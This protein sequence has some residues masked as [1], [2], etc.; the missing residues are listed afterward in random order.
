MSKRQIVV[1]Y[2]ALSAALLLRPATVHATYS[3][4]A[5][6]AKTQACGV[7]V[8]T[9]NLAV[10]ASVPYAQAGVGALASQFETNPHY[11]PRGLTLLSQALSPDEVLKRLLAED[12]N[13]DGAGP[14]ARQVGIVSVAGRAAN[15]TGDEAQHAVWAG[16]RSGSGYTIQG[17]GLTGPQVAEAME[18]AFLYTPGSLAEK[19][20][21]ALLAGDRAGGQRTGRESAALLVRTRE[22]WPIDLDL[23]VDHASDP[24]GELQHLFDMQLARQEVVQANI[25]ARHGNFAE[26]KWTLVEAVARGTASQRVWLRAARVAVNIEEPTLAVQ[27]LAVAFRQ[28]PN[29]IPA[30]LGEG[31]YAELGANP[32]FHHWV[33]EEQQQNALAESHRLTKDAT[34]EKRMEVARLLLEAERAD[35]ALA[36]LNALPQGT[37]ESVES[38]LLRSTAL[39]AQGNTS[40]AIAQCQ[41]A[42]AKS[43]D[44]PRV[45]IRLARLQGKVKAPN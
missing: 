3:I 44:N 40:E 4:A 16:A 12:G 19:L 25:L 36:V 29:W 10:G 18:R 30:E 14:E 22:G 17:N 31:K 8:Q 38:L 23:R 27:Y 6:D 5:C 41:A 37:G 13:F 2:F 9:N 32:Q 20:M 1:P 42:A 26:A 43:P 11:G 35:N 39:E 28:N 24:V 34:P 21:A 33:S 15:Y 7:A 45:L